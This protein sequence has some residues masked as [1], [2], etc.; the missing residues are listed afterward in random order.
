MLTVLRVELTGKARRKFLAPDPLAVTSH[1]PSLANIGKSVEDVTVTDV[2]IQ[3]ERLL[4]LAITFVASASSNKPFG[5]PVTGSWS[6]RWVSAGT[7]SIKPASFT[8]VAV[9]ARVND[10]TVNVTGVGA[11]NKIVRS[12]AAVVAR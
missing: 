4:D 10:G 3:T 8:R 5:A 6:K 9:E 1:T 12:M 2:L 7:S 11:M